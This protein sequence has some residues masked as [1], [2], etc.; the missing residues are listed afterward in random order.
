MKPK[1]TQAPKLAFKPRRMFVNMSNKPH[2]VLE[3]GERLRM[4]S[5]ND[6][7]P[8]YVEALV[9]P[10]NPASVAALVELATKALTGHITAAKDYDLVAAYRPEAIKVLAALGFKTGGRK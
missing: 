6:T 1:P 7:I 3:P 2:V 10:D 8:D 5:N 9:L 4:R